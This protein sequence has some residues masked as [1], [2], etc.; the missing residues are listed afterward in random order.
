MVPLAA[1]DPLILDLAVALGLGLL[2]GLEREWSAEEEVAGV[3]TFALVTLFGV[4]CAW[5]SGVYGGWVLAT[6]LATV[7]ALLVVGNLGRYRRGDF[8]PGMTTEVA[9]LVMFAA[10]AILPL[11]FRMQAVVLAGGVAVLLH[12]KSQ[13]HGWIEDLEP[14]AMRA[15]IRLCLIGLVIAPLLPDRPMG[16]Y[17]VLNPFRI[18]LMVVLIEGI[19]LAAWIA[20]R[21]VGSRAGV[22]AE[23]A[24][25]GLISSTATTVGS[26]RRARADRS[27][28]P[29]AALIVTMASAVVFARVAIEVLV[30][31]PGLAK[32]IL[33]P[34]LVV[35]LALGIAAAVAARRGWSGE[36]Q[37]EQEEEPSST[38]GT[39]LGFGLLYA[40]VL[41]G[42][43][44]A[45]QYLGDTGL[46]AVAALSGLTDM[47]AITLSTARMSV[48]GEIPAEQVWRLILVGAISN[49]AFK[50][51]LAGVI[52]GRV[53]LAR[54]APLLGVGIGAGV[55][56]LALWP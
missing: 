30:V 8:D 48:A 5:L 16:P 10:G 25:G 46:Y 21:M 41:V 7:T 55:L 47:D 14:G 24:L 29:A 20:A 43:A 11:G 54:V 13:I 3:R 52:G 28:A 35:G 31:A 44:V 15:V 56:V 19:T 9:A 33:P 18:W 32:T 22:L 17:G 6:G 45:R 34:V 36:L 51:G 2:V 23:G 49:I 53:L 50:A 26:A 12:F 27:L 1:D 39:A 42:V 37:H 38:L 40:A 4:L